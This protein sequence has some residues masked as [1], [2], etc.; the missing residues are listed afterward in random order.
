MN[1]DQP[2]SNFAVE[3]KLHKIIAGLVNKFNDVFL[4]ARYYCFH[5]DEYHERDCFQVISEIAKIPLSNLD[6]YLNVLRSLDI[7]QYSW[8]HRSIQLTS[9]GELKEAFVLS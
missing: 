8:S 5:Q 2:R 9:Q 6:F 7:I 3:I 4:A 1:N